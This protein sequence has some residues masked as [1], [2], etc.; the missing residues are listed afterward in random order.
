MRAVRSIRR[1]K[2]SRPSS[3]FLWMGAEV[4]TV[5]PMPSPRKK[6]MFLA[7]LVD[8]AAAMAGTAAQQAASSSGVMRRKVISFT[9]GLQTAGGLDQVEHAGVVDGAA[10]QL[11]IGAGR[12]QEHIAAAVG[13]G[14]L[15]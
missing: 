6:M 3:P 12:A 8:W 1:S 5:G 11:R 4:M 14:A 15:V 9:S 13:L 2:S 7:G 10:E